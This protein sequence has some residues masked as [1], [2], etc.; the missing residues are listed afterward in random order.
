VLILGDVIN[1]MNI[2]TG[3]LG[4]H[5]PPWFVA[6]DVEENRRSARRLAALRPRLM[7]FGHGPPLRDTRKF[8]DFVAALP[9]P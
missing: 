8:V 2:V 4:L 9:D 5:E 7:L 1:N 6:A 3:A